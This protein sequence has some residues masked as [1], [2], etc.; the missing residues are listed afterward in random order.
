MFV[1]TNENNI[2]V[3][4]S[5]LL[6]VN[7]IPENFRL[8]IREANELPTVGTYYTGK[9]VNKECEKCPTASDISDE[10]FRRQREKNKQDAKEA[11]DEFLK[12]FGF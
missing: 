11:A 4:I 1:I 8:Y 2:V 10:I 5:L 9:L 3:S 12:F 6:G 7:P